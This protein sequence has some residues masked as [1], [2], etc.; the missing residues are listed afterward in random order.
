MHHALRKSALHPTDRDGS[1]VEIARDQSRRTKEKPAE[2]RSKIDRNA[3]GKSADQ[4]SVSRIGPRT[5]SQ[6][7]G[8]ARAAGDGETASADCAAHRYSAA[9]SGT[10]AAAT[11]PACPRRSHPQKEANCRANQISS[12]RAN[13]RASRN[14]TRTRTAGF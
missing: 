10:G 1:V 12:A 13:L 8:S 5:H 2:I 9:T 4:T 6:I 14:P 3:A 11:H 7:S